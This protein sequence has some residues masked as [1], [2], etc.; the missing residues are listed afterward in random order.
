M[1]VKTMESGNLLKK[2]KKKKILFIM[3]QERLTWDF[4]AKFDS[5]L[6]QRTCFPQLWSPKGNLPFSQF[7]LYFLKT[8]YTSAETELQNLMSMPWTTCG[9]L[10]SWLLFKGRIHEH[11]NMKWNFNVFTACLT[12]SA[13]LGSEWHFF[14]LFWKALPLP[15]TPFI[16]R[17]TLRQKFALISSPV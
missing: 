12:T 14:F 17:V 2:K 13:V 6:S 3:S 1:S 4:L 5:V 9:N 16:Y 15:V 7:K 11:L 8:H 10:T